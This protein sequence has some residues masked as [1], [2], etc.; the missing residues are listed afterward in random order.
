MASP[1]EM[2]SGGLLVSQ[3]GRPEL[4]LTLVN[5]SER[6]LWVRVRFHTP[7]GLHDCM[8]TKELDTKAKGSYLCPQPSIQAN[9]DYPVQIIVFGDMAQAEVLDRLNTRFRFDREDVS[10]V[11]GSSGSVPPSSAR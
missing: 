5:H 9:V 4:G 6:T 3:A 7:N 10:V 11:G 8:L 2:V 1:V